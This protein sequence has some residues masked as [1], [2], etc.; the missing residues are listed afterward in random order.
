MVDES[1]SVHAGSDSFSYMTTLLSSFVERFLHHF[2]PSMLQ[3]IY[4]MNTS[5]PDSEV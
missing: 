5:E 3:Y 1:G 4:Q 2:S